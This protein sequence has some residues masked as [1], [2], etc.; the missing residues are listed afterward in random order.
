MAEADEREPEAEA[1]VPVAPH[2]AV[3]LERARQAVGR[4]A[5]QPGRGLQLGEAARA[6]ALEGAQ[7]ADGLVEHPDVRYAVHLSGTLSQ[8]VRSA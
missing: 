3:T 4:R 5:R 1:A 7:D 6:R 8:I 2:E